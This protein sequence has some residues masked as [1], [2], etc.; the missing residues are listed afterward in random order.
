[1]KRDWDVVREVLLALEQEPESSGRVSSLPG[2]DDQLVAYHINMMIEAG[3]IRGRC[4]G[5]LNNGLICVAQSMTWDGHEFLDKIRSQTV[6][7]KVKTT[8]R[9]KGLALSI[10]MI[11]FAATE[12][13]KAIFAS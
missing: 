10:D 6:W 8:A 2:H 5:S 4:I 12:I 1:M 13:A 9:E 3:L 11:K 7:N